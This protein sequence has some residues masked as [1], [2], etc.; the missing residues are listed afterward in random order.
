MSCQF[1]SQADLDLRPN[2]GS[3][4]LLQSWCWVWRTAASKSCARSGHYRRQ[5][6]AYRWRWRWHLKLQMCQSLEL[7][8]NPWEHWLLCFYLK[9]SIWQLCFWWTLRFYFS[10]CE[11][12]RGSFGLSCQ[13]SRA[14]CVSVS[15][16][17]ANC[18]SV[19]L[20]RSQIRSPLCEEVCIPNPAQHAHSQFYC[21]GSRSLSV[22]HRHR[23]LQPTDDWY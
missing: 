17:M 12:S 1:E 15:L 19:L 5:A 10:R 13:L 7:F 3:R 18:L 9:H 16:Q 14:H 23:C 11:H 21:L 4:Q 20:W 22:L 2:R 6:L 8:Q